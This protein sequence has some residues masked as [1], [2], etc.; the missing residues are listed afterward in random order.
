MSHLI[1]PGPTAPHRAAATGLGL[2]VPGYAHPLVAAAEWAGLT[3]RGTPLHWAVLNVARGPGARPDP[4]CRTAAAGLRATGVRLLGHLDTRWGT[5]PFGELVSDADRF[6]D[7]YHVDGF[8]LGRCPVDRPGLPEVSRTVVTLRALLGG[9]YVVL[10]QGTHPYHGYMEIADQLV[11]FRGPWTDYRW[12]QATEW[13]AG[14]PP[15]R[16]CHLVHGVPRPHLEEALRIARWQG[17]GTIF[18][19]DRTVQPGQGAG[20]A[21]PWEALPGYWDEIVSRIGPCVME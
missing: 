5:R 16:F 19:T 15:G 2:G 3:R 21:T 14:Y 9:A 11:T 7:W 17:A 13:T 1:S 8:Y 18:F 12:S 10:G 6:L 4:H 20:A